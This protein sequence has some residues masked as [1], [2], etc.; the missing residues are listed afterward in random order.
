MP[1]GDAAASS[2]GDALV[3]HTSCALRCPRP[4]WRCRLAILIDVAMSRNGSLPVV[5]KSA[6]LLA[7]AWCWPSSRLTSWP[8]SIKNR[9]PSAT[10][11]FKSPL[12]ASLSYEAAPSNVKPM[13]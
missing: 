7:G 11:P 8:C 6:F 2:A 3:R 10:V 13:F 1:R 4:S 12:L 5:I 9:L